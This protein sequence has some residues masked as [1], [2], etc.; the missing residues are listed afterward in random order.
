[1][2]NFIILSSLVLATLHLAVVPASAH[3][4]VTHPP[5]RQAFCKDVPVPGCGKA[6]YDAH[7]VEARKGSLECNGGNENFVELND[8]R[9]WAPYFTVV[10]PDGAP[11]SF[12]WSL[13]ARHVTSTWEYFMLTEHD[14]KLASFDDHGAEP[15]ETVVHHV[16]L[17]GFTGRQTILARWNVFDT[18]N[19]FYS[20][21]DLLIDPTTTATAVAGAAATQLPI[22]IPLAGPG[23]GLAR[24]NGSSSA[25]NVNIP[26]YNGFV[27]HKG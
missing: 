14:T 21:V 3:G 7:S 26:L 5:S 27:T 16:S 1:M 11:V 6:Q 19:A 13:T 9:L 22:G 23:L 12:T 18:D 2:I 24:A 15:P 8:E 10:H 17:Q 20:C 25:N 4:Y